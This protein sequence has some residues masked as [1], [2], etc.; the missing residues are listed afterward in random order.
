[1]RKAVWLLL[2]LPILSSAQTSADKILLRSI[3]YHD[4][5][6]K[7]N[8]LE[9]KLIF[10]ETRPNS[11]DRSTII[12]LKNTDSYM[13]I[14]RNEEEVFEVS[15]N[16]AMVLKGGSNEDRALVLR[17]YYLYLWGLPMKLKDEAT[18]ELAQVKDEIVGEI[19]CQV[20]RVVY[21]EDTWYFYFNEQSGRML[22]Y[23]FYKDEAAGKGELI[24]LEN[25]LTVDG[26]KIPKK[27]N[28]YSLPDSK[29]LGSD[30]LVGAE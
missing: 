5:E 26:I 20:I 12:S 30:I 11:P 2:I 21:Q 27:R 10:N 18:P 22:Q 24:T 6:S 19:N 29:Y 8:S 28:W 4:P 13:K 1:M 16:K 23:K 3:N 7:W 9:T 15:H 14:N 25:E 17:N